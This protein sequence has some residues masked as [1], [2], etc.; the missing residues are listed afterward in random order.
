MT[1]MSIPV[2]VTTSLLTRL[3]N[4]TLLTWT[5]ASINMTQL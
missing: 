1:W 3:L 2:D 5:S 4:L